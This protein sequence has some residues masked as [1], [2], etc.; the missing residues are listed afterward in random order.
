M[1]RNSSSS[2][3]TAARGESTAT[4]AAVADPDPDCAM[5]EIAGAPAPAAKAEGGATSSAVSPSSSMTVTNAP[6]P[7]PARP[8]RIT[9]TIPALKLPFSLAQI[10]S[11]ARADEA[12]RMRGAAV[13]VVPGVGPVEL[14]FGDWILLRYWAQPGDERDYDKSS[15]V[16]VV[17]ATA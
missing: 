15:I 7:L 6:E 8:I 14:Q 12:F 17:R 1:K 5:R 4:P 10:V 3:F 9:S 2:K 13:L 16:S 11:Q